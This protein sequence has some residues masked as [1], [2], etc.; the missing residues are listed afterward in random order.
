MGKHHNKGQLHERADGDKYDCGQKVE[1]GE[2]L[3]RL[4]EALQG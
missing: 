3:C 2:P 4:Q 1:I